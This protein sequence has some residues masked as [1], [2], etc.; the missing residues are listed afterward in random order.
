MTLQGATDALMSYGG[1]SAALLSGVV[2]AAVG[3][4]WLAVISALLIAPAGFVG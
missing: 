4:G 1:A 3:F 2:L